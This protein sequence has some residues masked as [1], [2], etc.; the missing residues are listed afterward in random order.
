MK[1]YF[2]DCH[3]SLVLSLRGQHTGEVMQTESVVCGFLCV[4]FFNTDQEAGPEA[5][6]VMK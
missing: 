4:V 3:R 6:E 1:Y 5:A 2:I